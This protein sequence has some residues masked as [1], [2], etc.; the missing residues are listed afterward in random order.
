MKRTTRALLAAT[1]SSMLVGGL[2]VPAASAASTSND[3]ELPAAVDKGLLRAQ[4]IVKQYAPNPKS[5]GV[6]AKLSKRPPAG[7]TIAVVHSGSAAAQVI[8]SYVVE[9]ALLFGWKV[10][11]FSGATTAEKHQ[12][13]FSA[14]LDIKPTAIIDPT[15]EPSVVGSTNVQ[16][17]TAQNTFVVCSSCIEPAPAKNWNSTISGPANAQLLGQ[18]LSAG[19]VS[20]SKANANIQMVTV[21]LIATQKLTAAAFARSTTTLCPK[22]QVG[23]NPFAISD[24]GS[25]IPA[26]MVSIAQRNS[27]VNWIV[28]G[29][30]LLTGIQPALTAAGYGGGK[31]QL[32]SYSGSAGN[33]DAMRAGTQAADAASGQPIVSYRSVDAVARWVNKQ[34]Q[35]SNPLPVQLLTNV[36][37]KSAIFSSDGSV[38]IGVAGALDQFKRL[39]LMK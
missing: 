4:A 7:V 5:V 3:T 32:A 23:D 17:S 12:Q 13:L 29:G 22:C 21:P 14:A 20:A 15:G 16:R 31:V 2:L 37:I 25:K 26:A 1:L 10:E 34:T 33:Y 36:N 8:Y 24:A 38:Y 9:A 11:N 35:V 27:A 19:V 6:T 28:G 18:V 30:F 39:W